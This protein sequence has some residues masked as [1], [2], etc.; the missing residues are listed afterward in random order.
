MLYGNGNGIISEKTDQLLLNNMIKISCICVLFSVFSLC[1]CKGHEEK[2]GRDIKTAHFEKVPNKN[3]DTKRLD[4]GEFNKHQINGE[5]S[6]NDRN[7][8]TVH[9]TKDVDEY[10]EEITNKNSVFTKRRN[11]YLNGN[12]KL[13]SQYFH[14]SGF[15]KGIWT[16][17]DEQG[18]IQKTEDNDTPFEDF[19]W[20]KVQEY[21]LKN[22]V[23]IKDKFTIIHNVHVNEGTYWLLSWDT[24][25]VDNEG[26]KIIKIIR[27][28]GKT[29]KPSNEK[30]TYFSNN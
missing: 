19:P 11:Y 10:W 3:V 14:D 9:I 6:F 2:A 25:K 30:I 5:W 20:E 21:L 22:G 27:L 15:A 29:G 23:D 26:N 1:S 13:D 17:Y 7:G 18:G 12:I 4:I 16:Y 8:N 24:K 28:D